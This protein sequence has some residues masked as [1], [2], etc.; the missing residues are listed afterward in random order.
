MLILPKMNVIFQKFNL[1]LTVN[2]YSNYIKVNVSIS[3]CCSKIIFPFNK[4][5]HG[6][7]KLKNTIRIF[8]DENT[9]FIKNT[10]DVLEKQ[11]SSKKKVCILLMLKLYSNTSAKYLHNN[12]PH[13]TL[14]PKGI[15]G[16]PK[17]LHISNI[18]MYGSDHLL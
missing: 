17:Q 6:S 18:A 7:M 13:K 9:T 3:I 1:R 11:Y 5:K 15:I 16:C 10:E 12:L 14:Q 4:N 8:K 2:T